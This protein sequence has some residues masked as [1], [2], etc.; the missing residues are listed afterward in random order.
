MQ[1]AFE[2]VSSMANSQNQFQVLSIDPLPQSGSDREYFRVHTSK[3]SLIA[4]FNLNIPENETFIYFS[5]HFISKGLAVP[6]VLAC[7]HEGTA[8]LQTD[9]GDTSLLHI[10]E[11]EGFTA[12]VKHLF[13]LSLEALAQLQVKGDSGLNYTKC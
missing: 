9:F 10:L 12:N 13:K 8:Y 11:A 7:N 3:G 4:T 2:A 1:H 6:Q 5:K